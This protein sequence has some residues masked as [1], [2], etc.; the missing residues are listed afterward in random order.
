MITVSI[1]CDQL[2]TGESWFVV[3]NLTF[4][5]L[6][7]KMSEFSQVDNPGT[8]SGEAWVDHRTGYS[9]VR[10]MHLVSESVEGLWSNA[11]SLVLGEQ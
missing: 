9:E 10:S 1:T 4:D 8:V 7:S 5:Q 2:G 6:L 11:V 3:E